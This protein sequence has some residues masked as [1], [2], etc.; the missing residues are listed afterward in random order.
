MIGAYLVDS[1]I[2]LNMKPY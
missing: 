2:S 1:K